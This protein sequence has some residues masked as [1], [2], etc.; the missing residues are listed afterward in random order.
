MKRFNILM[1]TQEDPFYVRLFFEEFFR[2]YGS[3]DEIKGVVIAPTMGKKSFKKLVAQMYGFYGPFDFLKMGLKYAYY[4][5]CA[6]L[7]RTLP[8]KGFYSIE[9]LCRQ[10]GVPVMHHSSVNAEAFLNEIRRLDL[11]LIIS[12]AAPQIFKGPLIA[13][14]KEGCINIHNSKLPRYRGMLPNFWQMYHGE[15][16]V[17]T[18]VHRIN[19]GVDD[20]EILIQK[21]TEIRPGESLDSII[22]RT[23]RFGASVMMEA[24][25]GLKAGS[26]KPLPNRKQEAT[27]FTFPTPLDVAEFRRRGNRLL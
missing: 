25:A 13:I 4:K 9:Q 22:Q 16:S 1:I 14:P 23:K 18:T 26:L 11:D 24:I 19:A 21:E 3:L 5:L 7:S 15:K 20:G 2:N 27:Y 8:L 17:G 10:Y 6:K 12:V